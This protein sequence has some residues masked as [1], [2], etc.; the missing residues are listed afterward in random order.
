MDDEDEINAAF[1]LVCKKCGSENV[2]I[3]I[4]KSF[5]D[6]GDNGYRPGSL[7]LSCNDCKKNDVSISI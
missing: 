4:Q 6:G 1:K 2:V 7:N 3:D 5:D